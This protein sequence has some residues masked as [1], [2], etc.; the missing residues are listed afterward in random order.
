MEENDAEMN[1]ANKRTGDSYTDATNLIS[2][3]YG[4]FSDSVD[5][6]Y[7]ILA[8]DNEWLVSQLDNISEFCN[9]LKKEICNET[10]R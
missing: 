9:L 1:L 2:S 6:K 5:G 10:I 8:C 7:F 4:R 3:V